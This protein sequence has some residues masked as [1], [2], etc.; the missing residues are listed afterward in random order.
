VERSAA[1]AQNDGLKQ[2]MR[3]IFF[4]FFGGKHLMAGFE[5]ESDASGGKKPEPTEMLYFVA[6]L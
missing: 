4:F 5:S 1:K 3:V 2:A 6:F